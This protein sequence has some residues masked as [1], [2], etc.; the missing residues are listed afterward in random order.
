MEGSVAEILSEEW[1]EELRRSV[2][3]TRR[4]LLLMGIHLDLEGACSEVGIFGETRR[5]LFESF[6]RKIQNTELPPNTF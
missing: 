4:R 1:F 2:Q 5:R 6:A 3:E